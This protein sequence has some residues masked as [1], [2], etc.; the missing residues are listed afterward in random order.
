MGSPIISLYHTELAKT[1]TLQKWKNNSL[2]NRSDDTLAQQIQEANA[3]V[4]LHLK[5]E[6]DFQNCQVKVTKVD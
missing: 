4:V 2:R 5:D 1:I 6:F 3:E